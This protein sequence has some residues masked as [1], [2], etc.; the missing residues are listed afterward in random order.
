MGLAGTPAHRHLQARDGLPC[1]QRPREHLIDRR[2]GCVLVQHHLRGAGEPRH[3]AGRVLVADSALHVDTVQN[4]QR[5]SN[6]L[7]RAQDRAEREIRLAAARRPL[8][9][10]RATR[11]E[12]RDESVRGERL[13]VRFTSSAHDFEPRKC[14]G[15]AACSPQGGAPAQTKASHV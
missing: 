8:L 9:E 5:V 7:E 4:E 2:S 10:D 3:H 15:D 11:I 14:D 6:G 1:G 13:R 12:H